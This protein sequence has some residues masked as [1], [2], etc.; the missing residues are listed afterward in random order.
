MLNTTT[1]TA[2]RPRDVNVC[3]K[4]KKKKIFLDLC[5]IYFYVCHIKMGT[6]SEYKQTLKTVIDI[7]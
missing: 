7:K 5:F 6:T 1:T 4:A 2:Q 3:K